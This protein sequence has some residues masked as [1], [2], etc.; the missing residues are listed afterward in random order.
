MGFVLPAGVVNTNTVYYYASV[1][2]A[3]FGPLVKEPSDQTLVLI[4]YSGVA[5]FTLSAYT[6]AVDI[7]SNPQLVVSFPSVN[8]SGI[9]LRFLLSGGI[10]GQQYTLTISAS[11]GATLRVDKLTISVPSSGDCGCETINP[12]PALLSELSLGGSGYANTA[13]RL[14]WGSVPPANPNALDQWYDTTNLTT[15]EWITDGTTYFWSIIAS[16]FT[17][18]V[19]EA[20]ND[21]QLYG[22]KNSTW[23]PIDISSIPSTV[24]ISLTPPVSPI[25]GSLWFDSSSA[26]VYVWYDDGN[27]RQWVPIV[28]QVGAGGGGGGPAN[29][30][31]TNTS[32]PT[33]SGTIATGQDVTCLPGTWTGSPTYAYLWQRNGV[34]TGVITPTYHLALT[35]DSQSITCL[36]TAT[37]ANGS[38]PATTAP[39]VPTTPPAPAIIT[40]PLV[41][42]VGGG[43]VTIGVTLNCTYGVWT[44]S[45]T[46]YTYQ[47][48]NGVTPIGGQI[49]ANYIVASGDALASISCVVT[50]TN[51][52]G[53]GTAASNAVSIPPLVP[54][55]TVLPTLSGVFQ[56]GNTLSCLQGVWINSPTGYAYQWLRN[57]IT[58]V[59]TGPS[60]AL[61]TADGGN[62]ISCVVTASNAGGSASA[63]TVSQSIL[64][65]APANTG[66]PFISGSTIIP[67]ALTCNPGTWAGSPTYA[68][69]WRRGGTN[70]SGAISSGYTTSGPDDG[71]DV[72]CAV[73]ATNAGGSVTVNS[74][75]LHIT[76]GAPV[77]SVAPDVTPHGPASVGQTL[78]TTNGTWSN[79]PAYTYQWRRNS[80]PITGASASSYFLIVADAG[81]PVD[82]IVTATNTGGTASAGSNSISVN[83]VG[84]PVNTGAPIV[85]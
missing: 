26:Q 53:N 55:N 76:V 82:C 61:V 15:Y 71:F 38:T 52:A 8:A 83:A 66:A 43:T 21:G 70:I 16:P 74:N 1:G 35:D 4:D 59:G 54:A 5:G 40:S 57:G 75:A 64:P 27:S 77:N 68:Y 30:P 56:V 62:T 33:I 81:N 37:N 85:S 14:F 48:M 9:E 31:P 79:S 13:I 24:T 63:S 28:N 6:F 41:T 60:Y 49:T 32:P 22:R 3:V 58:A 50:A 78:S 47:W 12:V 10:P 73:T 18:P 2:P 84:G 45:P 36:V 20:P 34:S 72:D 46:G 69:Q 44:G 11:S 39:I 7:S 65:A 25:V 19:P 67:G 42:V 23:V 29:P 51:S 17:V 80:T